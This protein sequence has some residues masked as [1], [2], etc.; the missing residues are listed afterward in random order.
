MFVPTSIVLA[1]G[2]PRSLPW[3][4]VRTSKSG[5][6]PSASWEMTHSV[7]GSM[8]TAFPLVARRM[9]VASVT[10]TCGAKTVA[11]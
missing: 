7:T 5:R 2:L 4:R 3:T 1:K 8:K 11:R 9:C 10:P 6:W